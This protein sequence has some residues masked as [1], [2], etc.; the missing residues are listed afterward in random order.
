MTETPDIDPGDVGRVFTQVL[1]DVAKHLGGSDVVYGSHSIG[2]PFVCQRGRIVPMVGF[3][4]EPRVAEVDLTQCT[5][6]NPHFEATKPRPTR[7]RRVCRIHP[8]V[9][10]AHLALFALGGALAAATV[11]VGRRGEGEALHPWAFLTG[12]SDAWAEVVASLVKEVETYDAE[13]K[14]TPLNIANR[15]TLRRITVVPR[16]GI[17]ELPM[18]TVKLRK[19][20]AGG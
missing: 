3:N 9:T 2:F 20:R 19:Y 14:R 15:G 12:V 18:I 1:T 7:T 16:P 5:L 11:D 4:M 8:I 17:L 10:P 6:H 13:R